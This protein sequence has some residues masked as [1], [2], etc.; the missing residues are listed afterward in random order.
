MR[1]MDADTKDAILTLR[2]VSKTFVMGEVKVPV[3]RGVDLTIPSGRLMVI[4]GPSGSGKT[5]LLNLI[6]GIDA[7]TAGELR[8][9]GMSLTDL[10]EKELTRY[11]REQVGFVFQFYN[12]VPTLTALENVMVGTE[13]VEEPMDPRKALQIVDLADR[14]DHFPAQL[15]GGEQQRVAIARALAKD[16]RLLLCDEPTGALDLETGRRILGL[17]RRV[18][19]EL[20]K[21]VIIVTHNTAIAHLADRIVKVGSGVIESA[22]DSERVLPAEEITW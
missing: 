10:S 20:G 7:P 4:L 2:Q 1:C 11:R 8:F 22:R 13:L 17:L 5:T 18:C 6:G 19:D 21:T 3:L 12:L 16:P 14:M 9:D 15:S